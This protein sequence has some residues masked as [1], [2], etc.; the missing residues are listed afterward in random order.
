M[1][2]DHSEGATR[3]TLVV[4]HGVNLNL[5]G[6]RP[7]EHYGTITLAE[8]ERTVVA[9]AAELKWE[10]VCHQTNH[11]GAFV[12]FVHRY[13]R[14]AAMIV[15]PGAWTHYSYAI[16]DALELVSGPVAEVHL[17]HIDNREEW[18]RVSVIADVMRL[19]VS[20]RGVE[21]YV[22]AARELIRL[23]GVESAGEAAEDS[24]MG[25]V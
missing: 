17:S 6:E 24:A 5:L 4:L 10:C 19:R 21:G 22:E 25:G 2:H 23:A 3:P 9:T 11:E 20:G 13:R 1:N 15:N 14:A 16:R 8:I 12:E 18:R 7:V